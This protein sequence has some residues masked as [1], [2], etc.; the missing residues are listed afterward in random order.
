MQPIGLFSVVFTPSA[1]RHHCNVLFQPLLAYPY[2]WRGWVGT[3]IKTSV[4]LLV[5]NALCHCKQPRAQSHAAPTDTVESEGQK[6][7]NV[8]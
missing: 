1:P 3:K 8:E 7:G 2:D 4:G 6:K 5:F